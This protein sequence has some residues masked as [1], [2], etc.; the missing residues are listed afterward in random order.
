MG[1][2]ARP[3]DAARDRESLLRLW[4]ETLSDRSLHAKL[5]ARHRWLYE[6]SPERRLRTFLV[7][8]DRDGTVIGC[9]SL[10]PHTVSVEGVLVPA[11][12]GVDLAIAPGHRV[13]GPAVVLQR[14]VVDAVARGELGAGAFCFA[15][16]NDG[17]L[18]VVKRVGYR[19]VA[20]TA[21]A[22]KPVRTG[23][24]LAERV[25]S[26][27]LRPVSAMADL[28]LALVDRARL[29]R[30]PI[31]HRGEIF[32]SPDPRFDALYDRVRREVPVLGDRRAAFLEWRYVQCPTREHLLTGVTGS[33]GRELL[34]YTI[35]AFEGRTA[36][37]L[38]HL[39]VSRSAAVAAF[40]QL[41]RT[42]RE[43]EVD[44]IFAS[45]VGH[46]RLAE[47][48]AAAGFFAR[49]AD[50]SMVAFAA[51]GASP[52]IHDPSRWQI[53]DGELDL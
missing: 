40:A 4:G 49:G 21:H 34:G 7:V 20:P 46:P 45:F 9:S 27:L 24:K 31:G 28:G 17:A 38:D 47:V 2:S 35:V 48:L 8:D 36:V 33:S 50:R 1:Y 41:A 52:P 42:L 30:H 44:S 18:P 6:G 39:A 3:Y 26:P 13:A 51:P 14:A 43:R 29:L 37:L 11:G 53:F 5:E 23:Y 16:P 12:I 32:T 15:Y 10:V 22:V 19:V 25:P